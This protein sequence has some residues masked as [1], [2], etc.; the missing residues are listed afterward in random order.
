MPE[1]GQLSSNR[2]PLT[3]NTENPTERK[4]KDGAVRLLEERGKLKA[5]MINVLCAVD[6]VER[7]TGKPID[8]SEFA[9][10][11]VSALMTGNVQQP[12]FQITETTK[13]DD[14]PGIW[15]GTADHADPGVARQAL[16]AGMGN[17]LDDDDDDF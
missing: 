4:A 6:D 9:T 13:F 7:A 17:L 8:V 10:R 5:L 16:H 3:F 12:M 11:Y 1:Y 2:Y 15:T 14:L